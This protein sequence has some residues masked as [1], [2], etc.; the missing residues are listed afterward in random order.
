MK[1]KILIFTIVAIMVMAVFPISTVKAAK[2]PSDEYAFIDF[3]SMTDYKPIYSE[4]EIYN[5]EMPGVTYDETTNTLT[6]NNVSSELCLEANKMGDDFK[7]KLVGENTLAMICLWGDDYGGS[8][9]I[10]GDGV[11]N[12]DTTLFGITPTEGEEVN[13][14]SLYAENDN[15]ILTIEDTATVN[16]KAQSHVIQIINTPNTN[17]DEVIV[18][19]NGQDISKSLQ[20]K[21]YSYFMTESVQAIKINPYEGYTDDYSIS[22]KEGKMFATRIYGEEIRVSNQEIIYIEQLD[23]YFID[24]TTGVDYFDE[25]V[26]NNEE[27]AVAMGYTVTDQ[28]VSIDGYL[29]YSYSEEYGEPIAEDANGNKYVLYSYY[30]DGNFVN[31]A[32]NIS[33]YEVTLANGNKYKVLT[34]NNAVDADSLTYVDI[35]IKPGNYT[36]VVNLQ[37]LNIAA[38]QVENEPAEDPAEEP[39][40]EEKEVEEEPAVKVETA[41]DTTENKEAT[42]EVSK[43]INEVLE[44]DEG[45]VEGIDEELANKIREKVENGETIIVEVVS[46]DVKAED[47]KEDV[48]KVEEKIA[49]KNIKIASYFDIGVLVKTSE[50]TL[51]N[52]TNL[53]DKITLE[54]EI[55]SDLPK[56]EEG[57]T[58]TYKVIRVHDGVAEI[59]DTTVKGDKILFTSDKFST[60]ALTYEDT[61]TVSNPQTGDNIYVSILLLTLA[62]IGMAITLKRSK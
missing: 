62:T 20:K 14:I 38:G 47:I 22:T 26:F 53:K 45:T 1:R 10:T 11:L 39:K 48:K 25:L 44:L 35:E 15:S 6:L 4:G 13:A 3:S 46:K 30:E 56:L 5:D 54:V 36:Y 29:Y 23:K 28:E 8:L 40:E 24:P 55:P 16:I 12:I 50:E 43:L 49:N 18:L 61:K 7:L 37:T 17:K 58:R 41:E 9:T 59:L 32:Y 34:E 52:V 21:D 2:G 31:Y 60:Y 19:K 42:E 27:E 51:G 57:Y 33:D